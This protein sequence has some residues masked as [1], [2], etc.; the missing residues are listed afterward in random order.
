MS[1]PCTCM[2]CL[3]RAEL[4][5]AAVIDGWMHQCDACTPTEQWPWRE[6]LVNGY[7]EVR[8]PDR[9]DASARTA[10]LSAALLYFGTL[11]DDESEGD[12]A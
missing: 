3:D 6:W 10:F 5:V 7:N 2:S 11:D 12:G 9:G 1:L 8:E 4:T